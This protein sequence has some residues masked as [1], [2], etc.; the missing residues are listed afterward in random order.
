MHFNTKA[1]SISINNVPSIFQIRTYMYV[2]G[3]VILNR[4][5]GAGGSGFIIAVAPYGTTAWALPDR[6]LFFPDP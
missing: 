2:I 5:T 1:D 3:M 6:Y 4:K